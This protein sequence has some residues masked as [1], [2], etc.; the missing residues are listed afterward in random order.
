[1]IVP[2]ELSEAILLFNLRGT[3]VKLPGL[4]IFD[5]SMDREG[6][7]RLSYRADSVLNK[8]INVR[9][10]LVNREIGGNTNE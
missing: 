3:P 6:K 5:S 10:N 1:M 9:R 8:G 2:Q 7:Y 4:G